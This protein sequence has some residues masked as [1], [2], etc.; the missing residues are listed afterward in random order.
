[1]PFARR[2]I[3]SVIIGDGETISALASRQSGK[4]ETVADVVATL[5][6][7]LPRLAKRSTRICWEVLNGFWVGMFAPVEG[8]AETLFGRTV[9]RLTSERAQEILGDPE[10]DDITAATLASP[11]AS[12]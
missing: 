6:V 11:K 12:R 1:M 4:T 9:S 2:V 10:I 8:Q 5:M 7:L 3:E